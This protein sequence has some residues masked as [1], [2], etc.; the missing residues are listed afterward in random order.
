LI[1]ILILNVTLVKALRVFGERH[2]D[3]IV[4]GVEMLRAEMRKCGHIVF[5]GAQGALLDPKYGF[6]PHVT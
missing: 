6:R 3:S 1:L 2:A 4:D 5:E